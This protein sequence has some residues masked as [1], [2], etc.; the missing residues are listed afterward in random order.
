MHA[1]RV[2]E[3][4]LLNSGEVE[5]M[6]AVEEFAVM[7]KFGTQEAGLLRNVDVGLTR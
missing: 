5:S 4:L 6:E 7:L 1:G 2:Y 3:P